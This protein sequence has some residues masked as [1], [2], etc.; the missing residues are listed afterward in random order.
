M[1]YIFNHRIT[2]WHNVTLQA[3]IRNYQP[4]Y[5]QLQRAWWYGGDIPL[6]PDRFVFE[7]S[8]KA[9]LLDNFWTGTVFNL[10]S[11]KLISIFESCNI[12]FET[13]AASLV[14]KRTLKQ[15]EAKYEVFRLLELSDAVD[16]Q[17][18]SYKQIDYKNISIRKI[19]NLYLTE[20][21]MKKPKPITRILNHANLT[22]VTEKVKNLLEENLIT[23]CDFTAIDQYTEL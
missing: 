12:T 3:E 18:T 19:E 13:F 9:P 2:Q 5:D 16:E 22:V 21:F 4:L 14:R 23:G 17:R 20:E 11:A 15:I 7:I 8:E 1:F 10:Y 6:K